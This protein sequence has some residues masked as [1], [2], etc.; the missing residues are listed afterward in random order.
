[1]PCRLQR[2]NGRLM[3]LFYEKY[4][5]Q[6]AVEIELSFGVM[7]KALFFGLYCSRHTQREKF[8]FFSTTHNIG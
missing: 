2:Q 4:D 3:Y 1:M 7:Y 6:Q 5:I 8:N